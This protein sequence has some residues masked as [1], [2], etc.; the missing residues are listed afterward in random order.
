MQV[1]SGCIKVVFVVK[2]CV[3]REKVGE[4]KKVAAGKF[5]GAV[6]KGSEVRQRSAPHSLSLNC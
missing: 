5:K 6:R 1:T 2:I 4:A 3:T